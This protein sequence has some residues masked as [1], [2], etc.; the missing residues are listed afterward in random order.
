MKKIIALVVCAVAAICL[1]WKPFPT[2]SEI[3]AG[4]R[5]SYASD[6]VEQKGE[7]RIG[8]PEKDVE[9]YDFLAEGILDCKEELTVRRA[10]YTKDDVTR[11]MWYMM[12][13][14]PEIFWVDWYNF[15]CLEGVGGTLVV[16]PVYTYPT[17]DVADMTRKLDTAVK[18]IVAAVKAQGLDT[19]YKQALSVHD[20]LTERV[21]YDESLEAG[22]LH[23]V[24]GALVNGVAVCDAY[25]KSYKL[26]LNEL[27]IDCTYIEGV[28][29]DSEP[30]VGHAWNLANL[31]GQYSHID[32]TW[33][34]LDNEIKNESTGVNFASHA[35]FALS[36]AEIFKTHTVT[37]KEAV[38]PAAIGTNYYADRGLQSANFEEIVDNAAHVLAENVRKGV[39]AFEFCAVT[40]EAA[41]A[42]TAEY[43]P[44]GKA[45]DKANELLK[46][47][48][49]T[50]K[51]Q[52]VP[53][54]DE[55]RNTIAVFCS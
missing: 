12:C 49:I 54:V 47:D 26:L 44:I 50:L 18:E 34:D 17:A 28:V 11:I 13:D 23:D 46:P 21:R 31:D 15:Y 27:G 22:N 1:L 35:F 16:K 5:T 51:Q 55:Y 39:Y 41:T 45:I 37:M 40:K 42:M 4:V 43:F 36:D 24:Y 25:A 53:F 33:D 6:I 8:M 9:L 48:K 10:G 19:Q 29:V 3:V 7:Y 52:Y 38:L 30:D 32:V 2:V 14:H 20:M